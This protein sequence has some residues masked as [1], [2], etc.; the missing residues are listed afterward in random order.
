MPAAALPLAPML[1]SFLKDAGNRIRLAGA[2]V[3]GIAAPIH[4]GLRID[5]PNQGKVILTSEE[6]QAACDAT[7]PP[8]HWYQPSTGGWPSCVAVQSRSGRASCCQEWMR[9]PAADRASASASIGK[10]V[11]VGVLC[12]EVLERQGLDFRGQLREPIRS[13]RPPELCTLSPELSLELARS[14]A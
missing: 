4:E 12:V 9:S 3:S 1:N 2:G 5:P 11:E 14:M 13:A 10:A 7:T 8:T 6:L